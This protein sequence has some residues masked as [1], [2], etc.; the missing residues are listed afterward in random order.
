MAWV[1]YALIS[2]L[3]IAL[4]GLLQK[5]T[6]Q[7]E[8]SAEYVMVFSAMKWLMFFSYFRSSISWSVT[9]TEL[10]WLV[11][12]GLAGAGAFYFLT[13]SL[14]RSE[15][16]VV[17]PVLALDPGLTFL[18]ALVFLGETVQGIQLIGILLLLIGTYVLELRHYPPGWWRDSTKHPGRIFDPFLQLGKSPGGLFALCALLSFSLANVID[19]HILQSV[20]IYTYL[21]YTLSIMAVFSL[22]VFVS[23]RRPVTLFRRHR[24]TVI[25][26]LLAAGLHLIA[27]LT[28]L[29]AVSLTAVGLVIALKRLSSL[30]D[31]LL[32]GKFF[33]EHNLPQKVLASVIMLVGVYFVVQ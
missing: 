20:S 26:I 28:Q 16:S 4:V 10:L 3:A 2:A 17:A 13:K 7:N 27:N 18:L 32:G 24:L 15:L 29:Q 9:S 25:P 23:G 11:A 21:A 30:V 6:L 19:R 22:I 12:T 31:V 14:R 5:R 1:G 8:H 33:H